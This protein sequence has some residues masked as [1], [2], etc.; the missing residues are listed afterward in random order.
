MGSV[1]KTGRS[2]DEAVREALQELGIDRSM[3]EVEIITAGERGFLGIWGN[4]LAKVRVSRKNSQT[5]QKE[6]T[7]DGRRFESS[8]NA[9]DSADQLK[10]RQVD[11][12]SLEARKS[13]DRV[14]EARAFIEEIVRI[15]ELDARVSVESMDEE[16]LVRIDGDPRGLLIGRHGQVL[17]ALQYL[18]G[19]VVARTD[20]D[21]RRILVDVEGYRQRRIESLQRLALRTAEQVRRTKKQVQ[22]E[23][24]SAQDR[25]IIHLTL[26]ELPDVVTASQGEGNSRSVVIRYK[27]S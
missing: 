4:K 25:R 7:L 20:N 2:V 5:D 24:M 17:D 3:A 16:I 22:M 14:E 12:P 18:C 21:S 11:A 27:D 26:Q 19:M 23:P 10:Q 13:R 6:E 15:T 1:E 9:E 8:S